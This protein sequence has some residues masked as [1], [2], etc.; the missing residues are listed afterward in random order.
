MSWKFFLSKGT[1]T[2]YIPID[3]NNIYLPNKV[4]TLSVIDLLFTFPSMTTLIYHNFVHVGSS[5]KSF[6]LTIQLNYNKYNKIRSYIHNCKKSPG[7]TLGVG[8][9]K[10]SC[11]TWTL[12]TEGFL[13]IWSSDVWKGISPTYFSFSDFLEFVVIHYDNK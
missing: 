2:Q 13:L 7:S 4:V 1:L 8:I 12:S 11:L 6:F 3:V 5:C 10:S 9:P